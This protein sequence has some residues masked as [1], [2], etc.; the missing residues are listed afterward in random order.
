MR[1]SEATKERTRTRILAA[2]AERLGRDGWEATTTKSLALAA[3]IATGTL[4]NYFPTKEAVAATLIQEA[5]TGARQDF[6]DQ[7]RPDE[8]LEEELFS[9]IWT[10]LRAL[11]PYR[12]FLGAALDTM[13]SPLL[14]PPQSDAGAAV[15]AEHLEEIE[16]VLVRH[17]LSMV[18][19]LH[20]QIY[21]T[22]YLGVLH[23]WTADSSPQQEDTLALLDQSVILFVAAL[24]EQYDLPEDE[25]AS[26]EPA[27]SSEEET[28][29]ASQPE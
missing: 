5:L 23:Y 15:R 29:D 27:A 6:L 18:S 25:I 16:Q 3:R 21:W 4:F 26:E 24:R 22:L 8:S 9:L 19:G 28:S 20:L 14:K 13:L 12:G 7:L 2:A 10:G 11:A 1:V 17:G